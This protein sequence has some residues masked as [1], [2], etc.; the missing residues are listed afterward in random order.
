MYHI[1]FLCYSEFVV[2]IMS[3]WFVEA[4]NHTCGSFPPEVDEMNVAGLTPIKSTI[5]APPR[6]KESAVNMECKVFAC[7]TEGAACWEGTVLLTVVPNVCD[8]CFRGTN[9]KEG[10]IPGITT[11]R[12]PAALI[13]HIAEGQV[14]EQQSALRVLCLWLFYAVCCQGH[15]ELLVF[16]FSHD[17]VNL[18]RCSPPS[19]ACF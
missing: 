10:L 6:I 12:R 13:V 2:S 8:G 15:E 19:S 9:Y 14:Q 18:V 4:A 16:I 3:D 11:R 1:L 5:V 7:L 17:G